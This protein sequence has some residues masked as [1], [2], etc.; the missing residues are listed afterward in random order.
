MA[1]TKNILS[2]SLLCALITIPLILTTPSLAEQ[3]TGHEIIRQM[4]RLM[5]GKT[6][7]GLYE[8]EITTP[9]WK[10]SLKMRAWESARKK[11]FIRILSPQKEKGV[12]TL[13][14]DYEMWNYLPSVER[15]IKIPPSMMFQGWMGSDFT[16]DDLVKESSIVDDYNHKT[17][18]VEMLD[19][20]ETYKV[21]ATAKPDAPVVWGKILY[22]VRKADFVPLREEFFSEKGELIRV[23]TF[24]EIKQ[25]HGRTIPTRW[26]I[27]PVKKKNKSTVMKIL[28]I[29]FDSDIPD[30]TFTLRN[31]KTN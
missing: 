8:M 10:R 6:T 14:I 4:D 31:L 23:M 12:S 18:G 29:K 11:T 22:W 1:H 24:S 9:H 15:V 2:S 13:R 28:D 20:V 27:R 30:D 26:E 5:W 21:E 3:I 17:V 19:A 7:Q 16:N 25:M